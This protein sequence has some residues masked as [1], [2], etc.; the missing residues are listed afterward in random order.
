MINDLLNTPLPLSPEHS[1]LLNSALR[2]L[3]VFSVWLLLRSLWRYTHAA[4]PGPRA[5]ANLLYWTRWWVSLQMRRFPV[6]KAG[7]LAVASGLLAQVAA[8]SA[9]L[10]AQATPYLVYV[11]IGLFVLLVGTAQVLNTASDQLD[12]E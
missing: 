2:V 7:G 1:Y 10:L 8:G 5:P 6:L 11:Y 9:A 3:V 4:I 12:Q